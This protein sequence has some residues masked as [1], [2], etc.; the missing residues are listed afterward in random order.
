MK[1]SIINQAENL[2]IEQKQEMIEHL[3]L[4]NRPPSDELSH[5]DN[6]PGEQATDLFDREKERA[7]NHHA[8]ERLE[9][10]NEALHAIE[11]GTYGTCE[12]CGKTIQEERVLT[13]PTTFRCVKHADSQISDTRPVEEDVLEP[14]IFERERKSEYMEST[15]YDSKDTWRDVEAHGTSETPSDFYEDKDNYNSMYVDSEHHSGSSEP[16]D[17]V[18]KT[19][20][21]GK[22]PLNRRQPKEGKE[23]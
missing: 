9:A 2:L 23:N 20:Q 12:V 6:H 22:S 11:E 13:V 3:Q 7:L 17:E 1:S 15:V 21:S 4:N 19:D 18:A 14:D 10:I 16:I 5:Y 8:K